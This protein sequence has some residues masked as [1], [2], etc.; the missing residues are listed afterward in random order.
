MPEKDGKQVPNKAA[1]QRRAAEAL[2]QNLRRRKDQQR[3][4]APGPERP[5]PAQPAGDET[6]N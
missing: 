4:Q 5:D 1:H 6:G 3:K 2:R